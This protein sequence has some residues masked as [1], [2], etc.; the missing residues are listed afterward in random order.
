VVNSTNDRPPLTLRDYAILGF[1]TAM[2]ILSPVVGFC[3]VSGFPRR[4]WI[5]Y[6]PLR[7]VLLVAFVAYLCWV[8]PQALALRKKNREASR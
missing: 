7:W 6:Y 3:V 8:L 1:Y 5:E 4:F 2:C